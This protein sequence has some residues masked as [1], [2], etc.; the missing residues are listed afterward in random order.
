MHTQDWR[1][2]VV[3][4]QSFGL[5]LLLGTEAPVMTPMSHV[6]ALKDLMHQTRKKRRKGNQE[7]SMPLGFSRFP[8]LPFFLVWCIKSLRAC[9]CDMS[10]IAAVAFCL[11]GVQRNECSNCC[12]TVNSQLQLYMACLRTY[13]V[14][15][16]LG[17][18]S[19]G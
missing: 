13:I 7:K 10:S 5:G 12:E 4:V 1:A 14:S 6:R 11:S 17:P 18:A 19:C 9:T 16:W 3:L 8:F 2:T 15:L